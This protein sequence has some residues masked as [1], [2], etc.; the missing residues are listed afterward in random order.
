VRIEFARKLEIKLTKANARIAA[1]ERLLRMGLDLPLWSAQP[2]VD[3]KGNVV[4]QFPE[5]EPK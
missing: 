4:Q 5:L 3:W 2:I 1:M